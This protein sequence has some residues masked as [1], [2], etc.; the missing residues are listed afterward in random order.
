MSSSTSTR[1]LPEGTRAPLALAALCIRSS[2]RPLLE[3]LL[4]RRAFKIGAVSGSASERIA[5]RG[6]CEADVST[7]HASPSKPT[8]PVRRGP[9]SL[10]TTNGISGKIPNWN[11]RGPHGGGITGEGR[12]WN[13]SSGASGE[14][15][16]DSGYYTS[17]PSPRLFLL[18]AADRRL[19]SAM[20][21]VGSR[22]C[23]KGA[24]QADEVRGRSRPPLA[25]MIYSVVAGA[26]SSLEG[27]GAPC[28]R[29]SP[30]KPDVRS[31]RPLS[32]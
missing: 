22:L 19:A 27:I 1:S 14:D 16:K 13:W 20:R 21:A 17:S 9:N 32:A 11:G 31:S 6:L 29:N 8:R 10:G 3:A 26:R 28:I 18:W 15:R 5:Y 23:A 12:P 25:P 24:T 7:R 2:S 4:S 30:G